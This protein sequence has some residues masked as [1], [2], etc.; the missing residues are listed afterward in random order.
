MLHFSHIL[1]TT[2]NRETVIN[3]TELVYVGTRRQT[4]QLP[5]SNTVAPIANCLFT[6]WWANPGLL[7]MNKDKKVLYGILFCHQ[8]QVFKDTVR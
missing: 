3:M 8:S 1:L 7:H 6:R 2:S 4:A 5:C